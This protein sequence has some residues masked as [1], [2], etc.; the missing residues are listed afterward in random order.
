MKGNNKTVLPASLSASLTRRDFLGF[1]AA[2][3]GGVFMGPANASE[4][5]IQT[6]AKIL[7]AGAGAAGLSIAAQLA[8]RLEGAQITLLDKR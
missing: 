1:S 7:I 4:K 2:L 3:A 6:K 5:K 8:K